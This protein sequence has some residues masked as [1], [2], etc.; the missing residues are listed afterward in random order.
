[1]HYYFMY[2]MTIHMGMDLC[3]CIFRFMMMIN[4]NVVI[5]CNIWAI[6]YSWYY[7]QNPRCQNIK[8][9]TWKKQCDFA[10]AGN[11]KYRF[12]IWVVLTCKNAI[13][14]SNSLFVLFFHCVEQ[15]CNYD[16]CHYL[17]VFT[18]TFNNCNSLM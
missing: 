13:Q 11:D 8:K 17:H 2:S 14:C 6:L 15:F 4:I 10:M 5:I 1:M 12:C 3:E 9:K 7:K 18:S 16:Y